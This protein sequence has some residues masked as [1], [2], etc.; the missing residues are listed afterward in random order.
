MLV[1]QPYFNRIDGG[2][3]KFQLFV[4]V[5]FVSIGCD[6]L[7]LLPA[8][9]YQYVS[10][11]SKTIM[12]MIASSRCKKYFAEGKC[13]D[14]FS[15]IENLIPHTHLAFINSLYLKSMFSCALRAKM[16]KSEAKIHFRI[17]VDCILYYISVR[18]SVA[19]LIK[20]LYT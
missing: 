12:D 6:C 2:G 5:S 1:T 15:C 11:S 9:V 10:I 16:K 7:C 4:H 18:E 13:R 3:D 17:H 14:I 19:L 8:A 20:L